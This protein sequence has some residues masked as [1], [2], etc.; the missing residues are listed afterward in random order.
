VVER[1]RAGDEVVAAA[2]VR[3]GEVARAR[4]LEAGRRCCRA[5]QRRR[6]CRAVPQRSCWPN[7]RPTARSTGG[8]ARP[9]ATPRLCRC[10]APAARASAACPRPPKRSTHRCPAQGRTAYS[11]CRQRPRMFLA[12]R[13]QKTNPWPRLPTRRQTVA[14]EAPATAKRGP[15]NICIGCHGRVRM[16]QRT[17][18]HL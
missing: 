7:N 5:M 11:C 12:E 14:A 1:E 8:T 13:Q 17:H 9:A 18:L 4:W 6:C 3:E 2:G 15:S 10:P 16:K